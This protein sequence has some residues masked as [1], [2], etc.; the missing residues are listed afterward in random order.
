MAKVRTAYLKHEQ[1][2]TRMALQDAIK[3]LR[4]KLILD[5]SYTPFECTG[6]IPCTLDG[7]DAGVEI[8]FGETDFSALAPTVKAAIGDRDTTI[9]IRSGADPREI[10]SAAIIAATLA[11]SFEALIQNQGEDALENAE[12]LLISARSTFRELSEF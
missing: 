3:N 7:E 12:E 1:V 5:D 11:N 2:P 8:N 9:N 4:F 10:V 6:Y